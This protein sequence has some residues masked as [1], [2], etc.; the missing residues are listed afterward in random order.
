M[1]CG[2]RAAECDTLLR[3]PDRTHGLASERPPPSI[4]A[5]LEELDSLLGAVVDGTTDGIWVVAPGGVIAR[6]NAAAE[7]LL[8]RDASAMTGA[9]LCDV[10]PEEVAA[11][12]REAMDRVL[13]S[14]APEAGDDEIITTS[15]AKRVLH[16]VQVPYRG[17]DGRIR[18]VV[19]IA[20]DVTRE[21]N[22][23]DELHRY[24]AGITRAR[25][26]ERMQIARELHDEAG[27]ALTSLLVR[28]RALGRAPSL[29]DDEGV[30]SRITDIVA[31]GEALHE[32]LVRLARGLH[33]AV[34][35][36]LGL[37]AALRHVAAEARKSG[38]KVDLDVREGARPERPV[39]LAAYRIVQEST[40]NTIRHARAH[41]LRI[42]ADW[43]A[44][45]RL[46]ITVADDG[47]G[48]VPASAGAGL[49]LVG[50]RE[51][52]RE[53]GGELSLTSRPGAG[54]RVEVTIPLAEPRGGAE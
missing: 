24:A 16:T 14:G 53:L 35:E 40:T 47:A 32:E 52:V 45:E 2:P 33:P 26:E 4:G 3:M 29:R 48:F 36:N 21:R 43:S 20:R 30:Q 1:R 39:E 15:G 23:V 5:R 49:G 10:F 46:A 6:V 9:R 44:R 34:L 37:A 22:A 42:E 41:T 11:R 25:D 38:L 19:A 27:Q 8:E 28:L 17:R 31:V 51:R 50:I 54:T 18:G 7:R 13:T 12:L